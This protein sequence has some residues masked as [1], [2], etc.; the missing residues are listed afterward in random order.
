M[1][2]G[3]ENWVILSWPSGTEAGVHI[4]CDDDHFNITIELSVYW[5][6]EGQSQA[7]LLGKAGPKRRQLKGGPKN[8]AF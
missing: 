1:D 6:V 5:S 4:G 3:G 7:G 8:I 2:C